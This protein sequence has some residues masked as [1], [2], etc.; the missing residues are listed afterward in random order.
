MSAFLIG[1]AI[2]A[3]GFL[4]FALHEIKLYRR[5]R[6]ASSWLETRVRETLYDKPKNVRRTK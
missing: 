1:V 2:A 6:A 4:L 5:Q 3:P